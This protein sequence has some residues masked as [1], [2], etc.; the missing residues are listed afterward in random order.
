MNTETPQTLDANE[1]MYTPPILPTRLAARYDLKPIVGYPSSQDIKA[2]HAVIRAVN[3][4]SQ[5]PFLC[6]PDL[7]MQLSQHLFNIQLAVYQNQYSTIVPSNN[8]YTPPSLPTHISAKLHRITGAPSNEE[9]K[10]V[11]HSV[12]VAESLLASPLFDPDLSME[13][14][15]HLFNLQLAR[16]IQE[17]ALGRFASKAKESRYIPEETKVHSS[18]SNS[19]T[20][21]PVTPEIDRA[22]SH[23]TN[24][25]RVSRPSMIESTKV[26]AQY[27][28]AS[29]ITNQ[30]DAMNNIKETLDES[31]KIFENMNRVLIAI[32]RNQVTLGEWSNGNFGHINPV[33]E[34]GITAAECGLPQL[35][36]SYN[37]TGYWNRLKDPELAGYLKFFGIG[38][39]LLEGEESPRLKNGQE[40]EARKIILRHIGT[41]YWFRGIT[42]R[43]IAH[44]WALTEFCDL[45]VAISAP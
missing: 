11:Q 4:E 14:S 9:L 39:D 27:A 20:D 18:M 28:I 6:D 25:P 2:I 5:V 43:R 29:E 15:Q 33:N 38:N 45:L 37:Q 1:Y 24:P 22:D 7:S 10:A 32:Q 16:H 17:S 30:E 34:Q 12:R 8:T 36:F 26:E 44:V 31:K 42:R 23:E 35:R 41:L 19:A 40:Q 21:A 13:L 3:I